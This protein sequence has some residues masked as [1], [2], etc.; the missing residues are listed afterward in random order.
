MRFLPRDGPKL[1]VVIQTV[2]STGK[3]VGTYTLTPQGL[4]ERPETTVVSAGNDNQLWSI[5][6]SLPPRR[7]SGFVMKGIDR[8]LRRLERRFMLRYMRRW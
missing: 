1:E 4:K 8:R 5:S 3:V 2:D 7:K 6:C